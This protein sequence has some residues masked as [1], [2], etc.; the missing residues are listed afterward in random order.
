MAKLLNDWWLENKIAS[1][2]TEQHQL[3]YY[4]LTLNSE[5][6]NILEDYTEC[7]TSNIIT[8]G[9]TFIGYDV[10]STPLE[11]EHVWTK[12]VYADGIGYVAIPYDSDASPGIV[13]TSPDA[14]TWTLQ[15]TTDFS[16]LSNL[17]Y[18]GSKGLIVA[19][20]EESPGGNNFMT[21]ADGVIWT[22]GYTGDING[23]TAHLWNIVWAEDKGLYVAV[24]FNGSDYI[25]ISSPD[26]VVWTD[27]ILNVGYFDY[28]QNIAYSSSLGLFCIVD[29]YGNGATSTDGINWTQFTNTDLNS[30]W[31]YLVW[32]DTLGLFVAQGEHHENYI[33]PDMFM[34][35]P[36]GINWTTRP[37]GIP[38]VQHNESQLHTF[39]PARGL[40]WDSYTNKL[41]ALTSGDDN[42]DFSGQSL[43]TP[44]MYLLTSSDGIT[45]T[46]DTDVPDTTEYDYPVFD[47]KRYRDIAFKDAD[48]RALLNQIASVYT[49]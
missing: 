40:R 44:S 32:A 39:L 49:V 2:S 7:L 1:P 13:M 24:G 34:T 29:F 31:Q 15:T 27:G 46:I 38:L 26:L 42:G 10:A 25:T 45:W 4:S 22:N 35:S 9:T 21:S 47:N 30:R 16:G 14:I 6:S 48:N 11:Y 18:V 12:M 36:D 5:L 41:Y 20:G 19:V 28:S 37:L 33:N 43:V 23:S 17:I 8:E 3:N